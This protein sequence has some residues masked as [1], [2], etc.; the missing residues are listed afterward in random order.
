M[1]R[2]TMLPLIERSMTLHDNHNASDSDNEALEPDSVKTL[3][4]RDFFRLN[5]ALLLFAGSSGCSRPDEPLDQRSEFRIIRV[6][7]LLS[8]RFELR[9][10]RIEHRRREPARL[11]RIRPDEDGVM[12]VGFPGQ[13]ILEQAYRVNG[14]TDPSV[15]PARSR[16]ARPSRL[17]FKLPAERDHI[18]LSFEA[19]LDWGGLI[20]LLPTPPDGASKTHA[21]ADDSLIELPYGLALSPQDT[22]RWK[23]AIH[24]VTHAGRSELWHTRLVSDDPLQPN[25]VT[26]LAPP[27]SSVLEAPFEAS[28]TPQDRAE[29]V[30]RHA[31]A[32]T[33]ILSPMGGWLD[34]RGQWEDDSPIAR[35]QHTVT[36]GQDQRV[37]IQRE[38]GYL[39]PFGQRA[40]LLTV[41]ERQ[42]EGSAGQQAGQARLRKRFF[43]VIKK[44]EAQ[45]AHGTMALSGMTALDLV[46]PPLHRN[47]PVDGPF[48]IETGPEEPFLFRFLARDW[49]GRELRLEAPAIFVTGRGGIDKAQTL[50][51]TSDIARRTTALNGQSAAIVRF[52]PTDG[53]TTDRWGGPL[54]HPRSVGDTT[55]QLL[56]L[57]FGATHTG[58]LQPPDA[59]PFSC[60]TAGMEL[61]I[62]SLAPYL[63]DVLNKG[64]FD[65]VDPDGVAANSTRNLG[66]I[67]ARARMDR[68]RIPMYFD[69]QADRCGGLAA[70][71]FDVD[72]LSRVRGP[73]GDAAVSGP[74]Y[75]GGT[76]NFTCALNPERATLLGGFPLAGLLPTDEGTHDGTKSPAIPKIAFIV[77]R[78]QPDEEAAKKG[79]RPYREVGVGLSWRIGLQK[80]DIGLASFVPMLDKDGQSKSSL[81]IDVK[82]T[83]KLAQSA[84]TEGDTD[85]ADAASGTP[86]EAKPAP[87]GVSLSA[88]AKLTDFALKLTTELGW[89]SI[90]FEHLGV[91]LGP[92]KP[93][94]KE[95]EEQEEPRTDQ[96][97]DPPPAEQEKTVEAEI[98]YKM[99][100]I[101]A[102]K[103]LLFLV[104]LIQIA[105]DLPRIPDISS[106]EASS[107]YPAKLPDAG[108]ADISVTVGPIEWP[109]FKWI[110][111]DVTNVAA[112][113]GIGLYFFPRPAK[114]SGPPEVPAN[115][116]TI[117]IASAERPLTL[118]APPSPWG[119]LAHVGFNFTT[120]G[121]TGFQ[122]CLGVVYRTSFALGP[123]KGT[124]EGSLAGVF[125]YQ[126]RDVGDASH[127]FDLV[128]NLNGQVVIFGFIDIHLTLVAAGSWENEH[129]YFFAEITACVKISFFTIR[130]RFSFNYELSDAGGGDR[131]LTGSTAAPE[132]AQTIK[133]EW[134][135]YRA[136]FAQPG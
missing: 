45:Y 51:A 19:L 30:G 31:E 97:A 83:K 2:A 106:G 66:E 7:D 47:D 65:L 109:K 133:S 20:P 60:H 39:F 132:Q 104:K 134:L 81:V 113:V 18:D 98:D 29:L 71:S 34:V 1:K 122:A 27:E 41:S 11:V 21:R 77:S 61:R 119:G 43:V 121:M 129:W 44:A 8:L 57:E 130:M 91:K 22:A 99:S 35:W 25:I 92:P 93:K 42:I 101:K 78:I 26:I 74:M 107:V 102:S 80:G 15:F 103:V 3:S 115:L 125:T 131:L 17:A 69:E 70:P 32:R 56:K 100:E 13:H 55:V 67:F 73:V 4:R 24:P 76:L 52:T 37:V 111:F 54:A 94:K 118:L 50:Y 5:L 58:S 114:G 16:I 136:A 9:N 90:G 126:V 116:F 105:A 117:R 75:E 23:H 64:W 48:W 89:I 38:D 127:Q 59:T 88:S 84:S 86:N 46:T 63:S 49:A 14:E 36:A 123:A 28:L 40:A 79:A 112:S 124:C 12:L 68:A 6:D 53:G 108:D 10:L 95:E 96:A 72:G 110:G 82:L 135:A 33:L 85:D 62:P 87:A 120:R 128:L